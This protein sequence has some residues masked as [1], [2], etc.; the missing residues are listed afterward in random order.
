MG[1]HLL[2]FIIA[3]FVLT[4]TAVTA[5]PSI[6]GEERT[7]RVVT[8]NVHYLVDA[9]ALNRDP[10]ELDPVMRWNRREA[11]VVSVLDQTDADIIAFQ[12]METFA[13]GHLNRENVQ[14]ETLKH[15]F[16]NYAFGATGDP[17]RFPATQ[18]IMYRRDRF[19]AAGQGFFFFS[20]TPDAIYSGPWYGRYP[21]FA[22]WLR[23]HESATGRDFLVV[24]VHID[25]ERYRNQ[26][27]SARLTAERT[28]A[29]R[30]GG[31]TVVVLG[32]F[33]AFRFSR[34]VRIITG[35]LGLQAAPTTGATF[36]FYRGLDLFPAIDHVL[37][38]SAATERRAGS[39]RAVPDGGIRVIRSEAVRERPGGVWPSDHY[40]IVVDFQY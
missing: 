33:N 24:N 2:A 32:D 22:T 40:P 9:K 6:T 36:H 18:P 26:I 19:T 34:V 5:G 30:R 25:R 11:A 17:G 20:P 10:E 39:D 28:A 29:V 21:S 8:F 16:P 14:M 27:R 37:Y 12:E 4:G 15:A 23:L 7:L 31:D 35:E 1:T 13:G 38:Y 3:I